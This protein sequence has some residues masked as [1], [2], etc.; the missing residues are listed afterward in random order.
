M[1]IANKLTILRI[2]LIPIFIIVLLSTV[3]NKFIISAVIFIIASLTDFL[4]G[5]LARK[6]NLVTQLGKFMDPLADKLLVMSAL[7]VF[8]ELQLLP[9]WIVFIILARELIVSIFRAVA[10]SEGIVIAASWWGKFK[11]NSQMLLIILILVNP[12]IP[13]TIYPLLKNIM[14]FVATGLTVISGL[15]YLL[16]NQD[17]LKSN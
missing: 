11:T 4:D 2:V 13:G 15:D 16:K 6:K 8:V 1:N 3:P 14:V 12:L 5:Y 10:A 7:L 9:S 17:V